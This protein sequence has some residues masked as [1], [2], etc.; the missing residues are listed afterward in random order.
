MI[1]Y[2]ERN[3][4]EINLDALNNNLNV[5][6]SHIP[7]DCMVMAMVKADAYG[8]GACHVAGFLE[9]AGVNYFGVASV[10]E[11]VQLREAGLSSPILVCGYTPPELTGTLLEYNITQSVPG[12]SAARR[13]SEAASALGGTL[14]IH[15]K[16]DTGMSRYGIVCPGCEDAAADEV[17]DICRL[18]ALNAEGIFTHFACADEEDETPTRAGI[19]AFAAVIKK[20]EQNGEKNLIKHCANSAAVLKYDCIHFD[21][22]RSGIALYGYAPSSGVSDGGLIPVM[23]LKTRIAQVKTIPAGAGVSYGLTYRAPHELR[24][25]VIPLGY[26]DGY[27]RGYAGA[28]MTVRG[29]KVPVLGRV[30]M[31]SCVV[32]IS[33]VPDAREDDEVT[34]FGAAPFTTADELA[35][36]AGTI[37]YEVV[38]GVS[39]RV[40]RLFIKDGAAVGRECYV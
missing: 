17:L 22:V 31:D 32:D 5:I 35:E 36:I 12:I 27:R 21:M 10:F 2:D 8:H 7:A 19:E 14:R 37:N 28:C 3:R 40:M 16:L 4:A 30:C 26:G 6:R 39:K 29:V 11:A 18:P 13:F 25:A 1:L 33:G 34:V 20:I 15:I 9:D 24:T 23:S 38:T